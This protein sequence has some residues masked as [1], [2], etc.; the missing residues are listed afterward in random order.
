MVMVAPSLL[1]ANFLHVGKE[2]HNVIEAG[3]DSIHLDVMDGH[4]VPN[5]TIGPMV[6]AAIKPICSVPIDVHLMIEHPSRSLESYAQAGADM[7]TVHVESCIH[8]DRVIAKIKSLGLKAGVSLNPSTHENTLQYVLNEIDHVL[9]MTVNP[10]FSSQNFIS[11]SL[12]KI[13]AIKK[14]LEKSQ[15]PECVIAVDGGINGFTAGQCHD[16]GASY[17]V[18]GSYVFGSEDYAAAIESIKSACVR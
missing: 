12:R 13:A 16:A 14:M 4:F 15:N 1:S 7:I 6:I 18:S 3:A 10:G 8:L 11:S 5:L 9:V 17:F 2:V